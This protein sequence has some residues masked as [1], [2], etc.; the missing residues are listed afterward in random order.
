MND[1]DFRQYSFAVF[2][3]AASALGAISVWS[4][5]GAVQAVPRRTSRLPRPFPDLAAA[6]S[7]IVAPRPFLPYC[8]PRPIGRPGASH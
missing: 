3:G 6:R 7:V 4:F 2:I 8:S 5:G 1:M